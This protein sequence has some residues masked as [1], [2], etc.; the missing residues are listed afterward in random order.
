[1]KRPLAPSEW[2]RFLYYSQRIRR[3]DLKRP[4]PTVLDTKRGFLRHSVDTLQLSIPSFA[5][6]FSQLQHMD[7]IFNVPP[8][9]NIIHGFTILI[10]PHLPSLVLRWQSPLRAG[11]MCLP[12]PHRCNAVARLLCVMIGDGTL[13]CLDLRGATLPP[14]VL[15]GLVDDGRLAMLESVSLDGISNGPQA[16]L[17]LGCL[18]L[19]HLQ[20]IK[21]NGWD[22]V[23][24]YKLDGWDPTGFPVTVGM[25][26][27]P[28]LEEIEVDRL[29]VAAAILDL[30]R[31]NAGVRSICIEQ[32][33]ELGAVR[34]IGDEERVGYAAFLRHLP[35][36]RLLQS[37]IL[38][39]SDITPQVAEVFMA[40]RKARSLRVLELMECGHPTGHAFMFTSAQWPLIRK[41]A[42]KPAFISG[43][44]AQ[45]TL[46]DFV[47]LT[48]GCPELE[49]LDIPIAITPQPD[50]LPC[51]ALQ[52]LSWLTVD[53]WEM[54]NDL[55]DCLGGTVQA[56]LKVK[57]D[58][59]GLTGEWIGGHGGS[60]DFLPLWWKMIL[61]EMDAVI[62][63]G[64]NRSRRPC[65]ATCVQNFQM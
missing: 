64:E 53:Q 57:P 52:R 23:G 8:P 60:G 15:P 54:G 14:D 1:M 30:K 51:R 31:Q 27:F 16:L 48:Q 2:T 17:A 35:S 40:L 41:L 19:P 3:L 47:L 62:I 7:A 65:I 29:T 4:L 24:R 44:R 42:L 59:K 61:R 22:P 58:G 12:F 45:A 10:P 43:T 36:Y 25:E 28:L 55:G 34:A 39:L 50:P 37:F 32:G 18:Q 33:W 5:G 20:R 63:E 21:L 46:Q 49:Y 13:W 11:Q 56:L 38:K 6:V 26:L 9:P